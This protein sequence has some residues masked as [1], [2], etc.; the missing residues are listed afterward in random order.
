MKELLRIALVFLLLVYSSLLLADDPV[1]SWIKDGNTDSLESWLPDNDINAIPA[2]SETT[3]LVYSIIYGNHS[4]TKWLIEN[5]ADLN[6]MVAGMSPLMYAAGRSNLRILDM[7]IKAEAD[8]EAA[9]SGGNTALFYAAANPNLRISKHL[10]RKGNA[11]ILH[12]NLAKNSAY[13]IAVK[14][15]NPEVAKFLRAHYEKNLPDYRD[16][17][18]VKWK[19]KRRIKAQYLVHDSESQ[20]TRRPKSRFKADTDPYLMPGFAGDSLD[21]LI[22]SK[23]EVPADLVKNAEKVMVIGD[24]HGGYDSLR[25]FLINNGVINESF[26]WLWGNG[27]LV[28]VGDIFD[29]GE[30]V[31]EALWLIYQMEY[32]AQK[33]GG[34]VHLILGN[35]EILVLSGNLNYIAEK[36]RL[37]SS[38]LN[39]DY[40]YLYSKKSVLGQWLRTKNSILRINGHLFV[41]AGLSPQ[42]M[43]SRLSLHEINDAVRYFLNHPERTD[44]NNVSR[45]ALMG[46]NGPFWYR[47]YMEENHEYDHLPESEFEKILEYFNAKYIF[48]GHTNVKEITSLYNN[49]VFAVDVPFYSNLSRIQGLLLQGDKIYVLNTSTGKNQIR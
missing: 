4:T 6:L 5:G 7:L 19:G 28:F 23:K 25:I 30:K 49:R 48:V 18:Y 17:P 20:I 46:H 9:D 27:H 43:E 39:I 36:Y 12:N 24:I 47:G 2:G 26:Q 41:H 14:S 31:T 11:D 8:V 40:S 10:I 1:F 35:H 37:M 32:L 3:L 22:H 33:A 44:F 13:D 15:Q 16:G 29:R 21:Y 42:I 45:A 38:K 34:S